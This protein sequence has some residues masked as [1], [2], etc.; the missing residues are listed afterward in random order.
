MKQSLKNIDYLFS[1]R[2]V[3]VI[4]AS[5]NPDKW[6]FGIMSRM[7]RK[8]TPFKVYPINP[9]E[10]EIFGRP[11]YARLTDVPTDVYFAVVVIPPEYA[12]A[13]MQD[14]VTKKVKSVLIITAGFKE[15]GVAGTE[16]ESEVIRI[17]RKG[18]IRVVG[19][20]CN[21]HFNTSS[22]LFTTGEEDIRPGPVGIISQSGNFGGYIIRQGT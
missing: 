12:A 4:G 22:R 20:N 17:A 18:G 9:K 5:N 7:V 19:P 15:T 14:C 3:A 10:Q 11:A 6:G 21:G 16:L 13:A 2:S 1:P 8:K